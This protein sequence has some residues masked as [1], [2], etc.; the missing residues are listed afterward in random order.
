MLMH[1]DMRRVEEDIF[2]VRIIRQALENPLPC[3][4]L[5]P[6]PKPRVDGEPVA[7]FLRQITPG[8]ASARNP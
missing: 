2:E 6:T 1:P 8:R 7:E 4:L 5:C 3:A